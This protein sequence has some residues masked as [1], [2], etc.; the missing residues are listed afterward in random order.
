MSEQVIEETALDVLPPGVGKRKNGVLYDLATNKFL[1]AAPL[2]NRP[3]HDSASGRAIVQRRWDKHRQTIAQAL[4]EEAALRLNTDV[5]SV[6]EWDGLRL[7]YRNMVSIATDKQ[8]KEAVM[9]M[10]LIAR[11][12]DYVPDRRS[13]ASSDDQ[14]PV[15]I[16]VQQAN[17][18][19]QL[20]VQSVVQAD[21]GSNPTYQ[22]VNSRK[23]DADDASSTIID[24]RA[25]DEPGTGSV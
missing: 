10:D 18:V 8:G 16:D 23:S 12:G 15:S 14:I 19:L 25:H 5:S 4:T 2:E 22:N 17:I 6:T 21:L 3:I 20:I 11:N 9:A 13:Q 24:A 1:K 7:A